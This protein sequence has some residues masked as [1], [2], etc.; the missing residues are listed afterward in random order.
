MMPSQHHLLYATRQGSVV[1]LPLRLHRSHLLD[2]AL[3]RLLLLTLWV[4]TLAVA[5]MTGVSFLVVVWLFGISKRS[6]IWQI[7][8]ESLR[9]L[10][11]LQ[12]VLANWFL[13]HAGRLERHRPLCFGK[14]VLATPLTSHVRA[15]ARARTRSPRS[16]APRVPMFKLPTALTESVD[17]LH[18]T[19]MGRRIE[20]D[21]NATEEA[22]DDATDLRLQPAATPSSSSANIPHLYHP[23]PKTADAL[24]SRPSSIDIASS[25]GLPHCSTLLPP[26]AKFI[27]FI[28]ETK[29]DGEA[30]P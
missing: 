30:A 4:I 28:R 7:K 23:R 16:R 13:T 12:R 6:Q 3:L 26:P 14:H 20:F 9:L 21:N 27:N 22:I 18:L 24:D 8:P 15:N 17:Q 10:V 25:R 5:V 19:H 29:C 2:A 11:P 1:S